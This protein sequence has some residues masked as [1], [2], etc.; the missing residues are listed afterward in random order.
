MVFT[1]LLFSFCTQE[2]TLWKIKSTEQVASDYIKSKPEY[3]EFA[4]LVEMTGMEALL[5]VR[6]PY[7]IML[8]NNDAMFAYYKEKGVSGL[9]SFSEEFRNSLIRN[10]LITN[11]ISTGDI[12]LGALR[13]TNA[14]GDYLVT[15]F[16]GP[17]IILNK[18]SKIINRDVRL[19]NGY[20]H[21][22]DHVLD[23]I[24][25]DVY[26]T[27]SENP[28]FKIFS[29]G[30]KITGIIDTLKLISF[31]YGNRTA[32]TR[33]TLLAVPDTL[34][35]RKGINNIDDLIK[36]TGANPDSVT[37]LENPFYRYMEYHCINGSYFLS[38]FKTG[39]YSILSHD[40]NISITITDD[41]KIN[42]NSKTMKYTGFLIPQS[43]FSAK[44]GAIH[45]VSDMLP[46]TNPEPTVITC[47]TTDFFDFQQEDCIGKYYKK[48]S[49]G[50]NSF[51]NIKFQGDYLLY[52]YK[53]NTNRTPIL[54]NDQLSMVGFWWI[55]ITTPKIMKGHYAVSA[56]IWSG[57]EDLSIF[58]AYVDGVKVASINARIANAKMDFGEINPTKTEVHKIKLV[59][60]GW[61]SLFWDTI[62][63]TPIK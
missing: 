62:V 36:W 60:T 56:N 25:K 38:D 55:E 19:A 39:I 58:D 20:A 42:F 54:H 47:E 34:Y 52:Y 27:I 13:D 51:E 32:R 2:P 5:G 11:E 8:P 49:D 22:I 43:N 40:N 29:E 28:S 12:G 16:E 3:S 21:V 14:I 35:Q 31:P 26:T 46:V 15:E 41:Y 17:D 50:Q 4:K 44:N 9:E 6:G 10:H 61:G 1:S 45:A 59:C 57:G 23:P 30:L 53:I 48:W 37:F 24:T 33:F 18:Y 63:F 7:T